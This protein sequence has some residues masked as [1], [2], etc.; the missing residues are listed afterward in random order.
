MPHSGVADAALH[1]FPQNGCLV[2]RH[3]RINNGVDEVSNEKAAIYTPFPHGRIN[4]VLGE[5]V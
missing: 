4:D 1:C 2:Q 3:P 5:G